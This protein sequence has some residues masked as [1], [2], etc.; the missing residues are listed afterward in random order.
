MNDIDKF[1][2]NRNN[3]CRTLVLIKKLLN[4]LFQLHIKYEKYQKSIYHSLDFILINSH[5]QIIQI[6]SFHS[7]RFKHSNHSNN[8]NIQ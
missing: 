6:M 2:C 1:V 7:H 3:L 4:K 5:S 8:S